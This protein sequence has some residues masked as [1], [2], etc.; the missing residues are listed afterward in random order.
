MSNDLVQTAQII[1]SSPFSG[2]VQMACDAMMLENLK[3]R[4]DI[5]M[6][7]RFYKW[8]GTW[9]SIGHHQKEI[10]QKWIELAKEEKLNIVR[11]PSGGSAVLH[12]GGLTY[13]IAVSYTHLRAHET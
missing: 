5:E 8:K 6:S 7:V 2:P 1:N 12:S 3:K 11:R 13:S 10:P 9:L 4:T